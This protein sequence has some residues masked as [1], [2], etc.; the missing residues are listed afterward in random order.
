MNRCGWFGAYTDT[1][2]FR[3]F[4]NYSRQWLEEV[5]S[6]DS[7][8]RAVMGLG[9]SISVM[10]NPGQLAMATRLF[11]QSIGY[12]EKMNSPRAV[13]Y[14]LVGIHGYLTLYSGD[15]EV[16]RFR[17]IL[18]E[19]LF[20]YFTNE[21]PD[22]WPW[23]EKTVTYSNGSISQALLLSG[24]SMQRQDMI[25]IGLRSLEWLLKIQTKEGHFA[26]VGNMGWYPTGGIIARFDQ[27]PIEANIMIDACV[28]AYNVTHDL[29]WTESAMM[30]FNWF[31]GHNDLNMP[32]Y[33]PKTG[34][35]RDGIMANGINQNE[36]AESSLAWL[37]SLITIHKLKSDLILTQPG[38]KS[39]I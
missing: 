11:T 5:G 34:G 32:L 26:P 38:N 18:A 4:M 20:R 27:Q 30:C 2:R 7:H 28:E 39:K 15:S 12:L 9:L 29:N 23:L 37:Q 13:A 14:S 1:G 16:R 3:N 10:D 17:D 6:E 35:C 22:S 36:G 33:D 24:Q 31:L 19:K 21:A 25:E 8:G